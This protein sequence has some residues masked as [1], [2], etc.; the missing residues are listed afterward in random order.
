M[1]YSSASTSTLFHVCTCVYFSLFFHLLPPLLTLIRVAVGVCYWCLLVCPSS[2]SLV[3]LV[4]ND[5]LRFVVQFSSHEGPRVS[6]ADLIR[7]SNDDVL[8]TLAR[9]RNMLSSHVDACAW[10]NGMHSSSV[11][12][13][14]C[15]NNKCLV[16][17]K[18]LQD[19]E[20]KVR[21]QNEQQQQQHSR[22]KYT[23]E[24]KQTRNSNCSDDEDEDGDE[25]DVV[26]GT[27]EELLS[28]GEDEH[29]GD[30]NP[31]K[32]VTFSSQEAT[33]F[34][35]DNEDSDLL[36]MSGL[37]PLSELD[38]STASSLCLPTQFHR[39]QEGAIVDIHTDTL[40][41]CRSCLRFG[42]EQ[43][44]HVSSGECLLCQATNGHN[45]NASFVDEDP[46]L[47]DIAKRDHFA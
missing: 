4:P 21:E 9:I 32:N 47:F 33:M 5:V 27:D 23:F 39:S 3:S 22:V 40:K 2:D 29:G 44:L 7:L 8:D 12:Q 15:A 10:C 11:K 37:M 36:D 41:L 45:P 20:K 28:A 38:V 18:R 43:C 25:E 16:Y 35:E 6:M 31:R 1:R 13:L 42:H 26:S 19:E 14:C 30:G 17:I 24:S 34:V 46:F